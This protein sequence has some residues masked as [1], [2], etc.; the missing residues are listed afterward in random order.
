MTSSLVRKHLLYLI[1]NDIPQDSKE[2]YEIINKKYKIKYIGIYKKD[3]KNCL[4]IQTITALQQ[5]KLLSLL[6]KESVQVDHIEKFKKYE[7]E[8]ISEYGEKPVYQGFKRKHT[9]EKVVQ[10]NN[11]INNI[12][13]IQNTTNNINVI[14][15]NPIGKEDISHITS[16]YIQS[17]LSDHELGENTIFVFGAKL[18]SLPENL[19]F[20]ARKK[21]GYIKTLHPGEDNPWVT[22]PK[23]S[24]FDRIVG[25]LVEKNREVVEIHKDSIPNNDLSNFDEHM[26]FVDI[27]RNS[28]DE[29]VH[30]MYKKFRDRNMNCLSENI[31]DKKR[32]LE[33]NII[34]K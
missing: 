26:N 13:N 29:D 14:V 32:R 18:Y 1:D 5:C 15:L 20:I 3:E 10:N 12:Q 2:I 33:L 24:G 4:Y 7:G 34:K 8:M 19:N 17:L 30:K 31:L 6:Q 22:R 25:N 11:T 28:R 21:D 27:L 9:G 23:D 16:E